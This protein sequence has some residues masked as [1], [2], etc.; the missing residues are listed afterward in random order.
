M[1]KFVNFIKLCT[2]LRCYEKSK[3][4]NLKLCFFRRNLS[5]SWFIMKFGSS[6]HSKRDFLYEFI[7]FLK[8]SANRIKSMQIFENIVIVKFKSSLSRRK[9]VL[10]YFHQI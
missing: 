8:A 9:T 3:I 6:K 10:N 1:L 2:K 4:S 7:K 5:E